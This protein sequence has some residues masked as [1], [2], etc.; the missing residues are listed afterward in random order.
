MAKKSSRT[1]QKAQVSAAQARLAEL[2]AQQ[3]KKEARGRTLLWT[4]VVVVVVVVIA[5][6]GFVIAT[7]KKAADVVQ[8]KPDTIADTSGIQGVKAWKVETPGSSNT[9]TPGAIQPKHIGTNTVKYFTYPPV[10]GPHNEVW[11][12]CGEY[13]STPNWERAVHDMEHGAVII[14]YRPDVSATDKK[15][16]DTLLRAQK[17]VQLTAQ[18]TTTDSKERYLDLWPSSGQ[19]SPIVLS[20]WG[21]QLDVDSAADPR[22]QKFIDAFRVKAGTSPEYGA[23]CNGKPGPNP[24]KGTT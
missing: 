8:A 13:S 4:A 22:I 11:L 3:S 19:K 6:V 7:H 17:T 5:S 24:E 2:K 14:T 16:L 12:N 10:G 23:A 20:S 21:H 15:A 9:G 1:A 18:G